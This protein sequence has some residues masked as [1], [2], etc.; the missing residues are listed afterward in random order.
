MTGTDPAGA[1]SEV[2]GRGPLE[3][4]ILLGGELPLSGKGITDAHELLNFLT[5][6]AYEHLLTRKILAQSSQIHIAANRWRE[7]GRW[8]H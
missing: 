7:E 4:A 8:L 6:K 2:F 3:M 1:G 5:L